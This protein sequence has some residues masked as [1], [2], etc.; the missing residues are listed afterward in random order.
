M[1][2]GEALWA[3]RN[4]ARLWAA[5]V[6]SRFGSAISYVVLLWLTFAQTGSPLAVAYVVLAGFL[7][8]VAIGVFSGAVVD[9]LDRR[10]VVL[11]STLGRAVSMGALV[12]TL[13]LLGFQLVALLAANLLFSV[14]AT[15][16]GPASQALL[17]EI[18]R[19]GSLAD[20]NGLFESTEAVV[21]I[22]GNS[23]GGVLLVVL[24]A[25]PSLGIDAVA[26]LLAAVFV[27]LIGTVATA[28]PPTPALTKSPS[29]LAEVR[30]GLRYLRGAVG[31]LEMTVL[32]LVLNFLFA[33]VL[34]FLVVYSTVVL[35][36]G[37]LLYA[38]LEAVLAAGWGIGGLVVGRWRLTRYTGR[39]W[40]YSAFVQGVAVAL[41]V[42]VPIPVI[43]VA[44]FAAFGVLS[45]VLNVA[46]LSTVQATVPE[47]L[48]GRYLATDN[49]VSFAAIPVAQI[50]GGVLI[51]TWGLSFTF[52][53]AGIGSV[54]VGI[55]FLFVSEIR[56]V[57]YDPHA[58]R[59]SAPG[60]E[61]AG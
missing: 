40:V 1:S 3:N 34:T 15:F 37:P 27:L 50:L 46:W 53:L 18:V 30:E 6:V 14:F 16:Y 51:V 47:R 32:A 19:R 9:R 10:R 29:V 42:V 58:I 2:G 5:R 60:A 44:M 24:G 25:V 52:L 39:L 54:A 33:F 21:G 57:G 41:L 61:S 31:L 4:F 36:G 48:Q 7:P 35:H 55:A 11:L 22:A 38:I 56:R 8:T 17:P 49:M 59:P 20:A 23:L 12:L 45:G 13:Q 28:P 43:A 26:Y